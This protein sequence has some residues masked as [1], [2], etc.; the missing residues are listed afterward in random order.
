MERDNIAIWK[1][2]GLSNKDIARRLGRDPS[3]IG[4]EIKRNSYKGEY[5][6]SIHA[7]GKNLH[8]KFNLP[9]C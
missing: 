8:K 3:T 7:Q 6:V 1:S 2:E 5:Y 9:Q 4:R